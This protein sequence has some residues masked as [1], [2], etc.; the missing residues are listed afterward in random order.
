MMIRLTI[1]MT[2][3]ML[4]LGG[5]GGLVTVWFPGICLRFVSTDIY[6]GVAI[7]LLHAY[8]FPQFN[9]SFQKFHAL[10]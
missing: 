2:S 9:I 8:D 1:R 3:H 5:L 7:F 4:K 10:M 6:R